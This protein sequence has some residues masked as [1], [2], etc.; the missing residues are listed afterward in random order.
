MSVT[1]RLV[2]RRI[3]PAGVPASD[4][5]LHYCLLVFGAFAFRQHVTDPVEGLALSAGVVVALVVFPPALL[6]D[7]RRV[8]ADTDWTPR[9]WL[10]LPMGLVPNPIGFL[11]V[12]DYLRKRRM[13]LRDG[14]ADLGEPLA[15]QLTRLFGPAVAAVFVLGAL[16]D[17][18][19]FSA[20]PATVRYGTVLGVEAAFYLVYVR[21]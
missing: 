9:R 13:A 14:G 15:R 2:R 10:Y 17:A 18:S 7:A 5:A 16:A 12:G 4:L 20:A 3:W 8:A 1:D 11:A 21:R 6:L 19:G